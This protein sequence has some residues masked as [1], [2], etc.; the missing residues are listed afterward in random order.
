ARET[1]RRQDEALRFVHPGL[2]GLWAVACGEVRLWER[3]PQHGDFGVARFGLGRVALAAP[4]TLDTGRD[5]LAQREPELLAAAEAIVGQHGEVADLPVVADLRGQPV[6]SVVGPPDLTRAV[7]RSLVVELA[8]FCCPE[9]L[10]LAV[11]HP[12]G[13]ET[14]WEFAGWL[15]H[16]MQEDSGQVLV[17][18]GQ[19]VLPLLGDEVGRRRERLRRR[20]SY[21]RRAGDEEP[22]RHILLVVDG[23][24]AGSP[25]ARVDLLNELTE[26]ARDLGAGLVF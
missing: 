11:C 7:A 21:D 8:T 20:A 2:P 13:A 12:A 10:A 18:E 4:L 23:Y 3:R 24:A 14:A 6:V 5:P 9:D 16:A 1:A 17:G 22:G 15:P 26:R 25:L 19:R